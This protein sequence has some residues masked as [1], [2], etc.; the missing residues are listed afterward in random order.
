MKKTS[1]L[2]LALLSILTFES[3]DNTPLPTINLMSPEEGTELYAGSGVHFVAELS[4]SIMLSSYTI[5]L[6]ANEGGEY[7]KSKKPEKTDKHIFL[8]SCGKV[9][10][11][12]S[13]RDPYSRRCGRG[14]LLFCDPL[15][16]HRRKGSVRGEQ[17]ETG[18]LRTS[19]Y[20]YYTSIRSSLLFYIDQTF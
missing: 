3:C 17:C 4:D 1:L 12:A 10:R 19:D 13:S 5:E 7:S 11:F 6:L 14:R 2:L 20:T 16:K 8:G 18:A 15:Q 9:C